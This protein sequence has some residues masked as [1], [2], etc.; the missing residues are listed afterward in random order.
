MTAISARA[1]ACYLASRENPE[2]ALCPNKPLLTPETED[3]AIE[4]HHEWE[5]EGRRA[6]ALHEA[7]ATHAQGS[8]EETK[9]AKK[10]TLK[11]KEN[12]IAEKQKASSP[13]DPPGTKRYR[14]DPRSLT[15]NLYDTISMQAITS[16]HLPNPAKWFTSRL[17]PEGEETKYPILTPSHRPEKHERRE[18]RE[19]RFEGHVHLNRNTS[20][21]SEP[22]KEQTNS[23]QSASPKP[24]AGL[25]RTKDKSYESHAT[26]INGHPSSPMKPRRSSSLLTEVDTELSREGKEISKHFKQSRPLPPMTPHNQIL[27]KANGTPPE[28]IK[29]RRHRN[30]KKKERIVYDSNAHK[31]RRDSWNGSKMPQLPSS[32]KPIITSEQKVRKPRARAN[33]HEAGSQLYYKPLEFIR[34]PESLSHLTCETI[35]GLAS[36]LQSHDPC[37][38]QERAW[39]RKY[40]LTAG[41]KTSRTYREAYAFAEQSVFYAFGNADG[42]LSSFRDSSSVDIDGTNISKKHMCYKKMDRGFR[43]LMAAHSS[44]VYKSLWFGIEPLM[45]P[46]PELMSPRS[47]RLKA[48]MTLPL[49]SSSSP[50]VLSLQ[51]TVPPKSYID[52]VDAAHMIKICLHALSAA[53]PKVGRNVWLTTRN[54]R[55]NGR[56]VPDFSMN[57]TQSDLWDPLVCISDAL[58]DE[59]G[60]RLVR[61]LVKVISARESYHEM[62]KNK[63][64]SRSGSFAEDNSQ[65]KMLELVWDYLG[66]SVET[67]NPMDGEPP[68]LFFDGLPVRLEAEPSW[69]MA[70]ITLEWVRSLLLKEWDGKYEVARSSLAG[71][72]LAL[73]SLL[74]RLST[75]L[76]HIVLRHGQIRDE[77]A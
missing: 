23:T 63:A 42:L 35:E 16:F 5:E 13:D 33:Q 44:L 29:E 54:L 47:P 18:R 56:L 60:I 2:E 39:L 20:P 72:C 3:N 66:R 41:P 17:A 25:N 74:C 75:P 68:T 59:L 52:D 6:Q 34:P 26:K 50:T 46:P 36:L 21:T 8:T 31:A 28:V 38:P 64:F 24:L 70:A 48:A 22:T 62:L 43:S 73:L 58:E 19:K 14:K 11:E 57:Y 67:P 76:S 53:L 37:S 32:A 1:V 69:S 49:I 27:E 51:R 30:L 12:S 7:N 9:A 65:S 71:C 4:S 77:T 15:Q 55:C 61:R 45:L 10:T 40:G